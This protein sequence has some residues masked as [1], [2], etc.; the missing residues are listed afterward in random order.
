MDAKKAL[1]EEFTNAHEGYLRALAEHVP[2]EA[3]K[4]LLDE[5]INKAQDIL[6]KAD[7][8]SEDD[9]KGFIGSVKEAQEN[10]VIP[11]GA[12]AKDVLM[13][14]LRTQD[15]VVASTFALKVDQEQK[16]AIVIGVLE[17]T[18]NL[19]ADTIAQIATVGSTSKKATW[20]VNKE[21]NKI[22]SEA[23]LLLTSISEAVKQGN[24]LAIKLPDVDKAKYKEFMN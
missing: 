3:R 13:N 4:E 9:F 18:N 23:T 21:V 22:A 15:L 6:A 2:P 24:V 10:I 16:Q 19:V 7:S 8:L 12:C 14:F 11:R 1:I 20:E 17:L 5:S